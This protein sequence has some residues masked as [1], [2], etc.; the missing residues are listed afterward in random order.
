MYIDLILTSDNAIAV[1]S[2]NQS[3]MKKARGLKKKIH[4]HIESKVKNIK[5]IHKALNNLAR[6]RIIEVLGDG[7]LNQ[8][9]EMMK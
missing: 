1:I 8:K 7:I 5:K 3:I 9:R 2:R 6:G 4:K